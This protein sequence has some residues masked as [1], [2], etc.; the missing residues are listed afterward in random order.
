MGGN[1]I[2]LEKIKKIIIISGG[3]SG[4]ASI[5]V[6]HLL[7]HGD[8]FLLYNNNKPKFVNK[9]IKSIKFNFLKNNNKELEK[10]FFKKQF[11]N[12]VFI[13]FASYKSDNLLINTSF[14]EF[15]KSF[16]INVN[17][18]FL[19]IK[20]LL[21]KMIKDRFGRIINISST[22]GLR[23]DIGTVLY[24]ASKLSNQGI[25]S[26]ISKEYAKFNIT[27][28]SISLGSF[29]AG[30]YKKLNKKQQANIISKIPAKKNGEFSNIL[31]AILFIINSEYVN[32]ATINVDGGM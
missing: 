28:N 29:N 21:K 20:I 5:V 25:V 6:P 1:N 13:N 12:I 19:I 31:N 15:Q 7:K 30:L 3:S 10:F 18:F 8:I 11:K 2:K 14:A 4:V 32:G 17:S 27:S 23:G 22:G 26:V 16:K 9:R 24:T